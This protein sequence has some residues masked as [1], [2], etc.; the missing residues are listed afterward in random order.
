MVDL[1]AAGKLPLRVTHNDTK[2]NNIL[3]D[4]TTGEYSDRKRIFIKT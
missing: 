1:L 4:K 3:F 2:L